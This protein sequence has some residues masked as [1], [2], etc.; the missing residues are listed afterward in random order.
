MQ[1]FASPAEKGT[2]YPTDEE[3]VMG[4]KRHT[5]LQESVPGLRLTVMG[6]S[7]W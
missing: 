1:A 7:Q 4:K 2:S 5:P 6:L 3:G